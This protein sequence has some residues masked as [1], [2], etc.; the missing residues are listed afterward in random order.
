M[1]III[2]YIWCQTCEDSADRPGG[3]PG[4][5]V[6]I[7]DGEAQPCVWLEPGEGDL[8]ILDLKELWILAH[9][10]I[11]NRSLTLT[12]HL[13]LSYILKAA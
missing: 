4:V 3:V 12:C 11:S 13:E 10:N 1:R 6:I 2:D 5:G 8:T 9:R 7:G